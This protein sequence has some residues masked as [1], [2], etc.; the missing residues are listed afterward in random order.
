MRA[1][2]FAVVA[3]LFII[4][5]LAALGVTLVTISAGQQRGQA[6]DAL[7]IKA[8]QAAKAGIEFGV[9]QAVRNGN[10]AT[11]TFALAGNLA[12]FSVQ[13]QCTSTSH[14]EV[15]AVPAITVYQITATGCN[16]GACPGTADATYVERQLRSTVSSTTP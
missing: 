10:C 5:V 4:V 7:S 14:T 12:G 13:V 1:R 6:F 8:Y 3:V 15:V 16:R 9:Y 2:G 11:T